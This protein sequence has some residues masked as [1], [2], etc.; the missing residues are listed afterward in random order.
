MNGTVY[1]YVFQVL[2]TEASAQLQIHQQACSVL[3]H[4][5]QG[6]SLDEVEA[7]RLILLSG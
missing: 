1:N 3:K 4:I 7:E 5:R 6:G 2:L